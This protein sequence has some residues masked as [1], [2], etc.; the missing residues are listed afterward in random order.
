MNVNVKNEIE[1]EKCEKIKSFDYNS[2]I[3]GFN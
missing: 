1:G 2:I 3:A